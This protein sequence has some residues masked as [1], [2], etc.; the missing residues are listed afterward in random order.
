[1]HDMTPTRP[2]A[3]QKGLDYQVPPFPGGLG[4][5][6]GVCVI[7]FFQ[8]HRARNVKVCQGYVYNLGQVSGAI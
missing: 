3:T 7:S 6:G 2:E 8:P 1:M 4:L 5:G